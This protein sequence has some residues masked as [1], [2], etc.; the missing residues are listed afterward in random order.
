MIKR[1]WLLLCIIFLLGLSLRAVDL[2][3]GL[4]SDEVHWLERSPSF[5]DA[6]FKHDWINTYQSP[7]PGVVT[8]W[9]SGLFLR[10]MPASNFPLHLSIARAPI[11]L[12]TSL[13]IVIIFYFVRVLFNTKIALLSS[14][15]IALDPYLLAHS[16]LIH[17][18]AMLTTF[19][20]L[21]VL[22]TM[23]FLIQRKPY[24]IITSGVFAGLAL[25][26]KMPS[27][28]LLL[29][30]PA[31]V[32]ILTDNKKESVKY[33]FMFGLTAMLTFFLLWPSLW[34]D[35]I[36]TIAKMLM[37]KGCGLEVVI[38]KPH[39]SGFLMGEI[40]DGDY[41]P[42]YY[43]VSFLL[44]S[45]PI[46]LLF[47]LLSIGAFVKSTAWENL[48]SFNKNILILISY[49][50]LFTA[51]M[52]IPLKVSIRYLLPIYP[53]VDILAGIGLFLIFKNYINKKLALC[54]LLISIIIIQMSLLLPIAPYFL[55]YSNPLVFG[56]PSHSPEI[57]LRGW[58]E[59]NDLAAQYLN[60]KPD[61]KNL[62]V[63]AQYSGFEQYFHGKTI[64]LVGERGNVS[65]IDADYVVFYTCAVQ[66][67][68]NE[69][70]WSLYKSRDPEKIIR[71]NGI[72][73]CL[74]YKFNNSEI[75]NL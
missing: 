39:G 73:Y 20:I 59:G 14:A 40:S 11:V 47:S 3:T 53:A 23:T 75:L 18:D 52:A 35:P 67:N 27:I 54:L 38:T 30:I 5:I 28:F 36:H 56:G 6:V 48:N 72:D 51:Q 42:L 41:G 15:L 71:L 17:Q 2:G 8:M 37:D 50:M 4:T 44:M 32:I 12:I 63:V 64:S 57:T 55:S 62:R 65:Q 66:R 1:T 10:F 16:R 34:V 69:N 9:V 74:I 61:A 45:S 29:F 22:A 60:E 46:A 43:P 68:F 26:T 49:I 33:I 7:H 70:L 24:L 31:I 58:G 21:S 13:S 19:M 25:L